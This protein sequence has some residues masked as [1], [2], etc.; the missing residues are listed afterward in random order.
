MINYLEL[1]ISFKI[2]VIMLI[3]SIKFP[4]LGHFELIIF[5]SYRKYTI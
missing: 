3:K 5:S 2:H 4:G 1:A